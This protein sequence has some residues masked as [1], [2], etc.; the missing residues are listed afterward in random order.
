MI[1]RQTITDTFQFRH[2]TKRFDDSKKITDEDF[3]TILESAQL[4]PS[5]FG[6]EQW[7]II[8]LQNPDIRAELAASSWGAKGQLPTASHFIVMTGKTAPELLPG[9]AHLE[10]VLREVKGKTGAAAASTQKFYK[11]WL[12][13]DFKFTTP[14]LIHQHAARQAYIALGNMMTV[15]AMLGIDSCPIEGF[16]IDETTRILQQHGLLDPTVDL[17]VVMAAFGYRINEQPAKTRR[18]LEQIVTWAQ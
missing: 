4:S 1:D 8:V 11:K 3:A 10:N 14:E 15:A 12:D 18:P 6:F 17:P 7:N 9:G 2:A 16:N 5:S 13:N